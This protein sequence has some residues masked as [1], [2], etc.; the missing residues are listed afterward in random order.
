M[1][2]AERRASLSHVSRLV[3]FEAER[4]TPRA[5]L[6][7]TPLAKVL[8]ALLDALPRHTLRVGLFT[9]ALSPE[10]LRLLERM[11]N[12]RE[13]LAH[14]RSAHASY[15]ERRRAAS[16]GECHVAPSGRGLAVVAGS[17]GSFRRTDTI[18]LRTA[19]R[20]GDRPRPLREAA[21]DGAA[22]FWYADL[23]ALHPE[24]DAWGWLI[25]EVD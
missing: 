15:C 19:P 21:Y 25:P 20:W 24:Q 12:G 9:R 1:R 10:V 5:V 2:L 3:F 16:E 17:P 7:A 22:A 14:V 13:S 11:S 8:S 4:V 18:A 6:S 23:R